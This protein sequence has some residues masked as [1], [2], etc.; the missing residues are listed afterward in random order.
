MKEVKRTSEIKIKVH[1]NK[2]NIPVDMEWSATDAPFEGDRPCKAMLLSLWDGQEN[3]AMRIDLWTKEMRVDE[4]DH[5]VYQTLMTLS[6]SY[7][8]ATNNPK[9]AEDI[10]LFGKHFADKSGILKK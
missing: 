7:L 3:N 8:R 2:D 6:D 5:L 9:G 10:R 1:L 4:M